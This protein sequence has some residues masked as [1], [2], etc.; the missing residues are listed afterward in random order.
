MLRTIK[1]CISLR[2]KF[3]PGIIWLIIRSVQ[4]LTDS[5]INPAESPSGS[6][7]SSESLFRCGISG[8]C[9]ITL[10]S[11]SSIS[12]NSPNMSSIWLWP[13]TLHHRQS[14][15]SLLLPFLWHFRQ[16][17]PSWNILRIIWFSPLSFLFRL[18]YVVPTACYRCIPLLSSFA[19]SGSLN[20]GW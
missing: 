10:I 20:Q 19:E 9:T 8:F 11:L 1:W 17:W 2:S 6:S 7:N 4:N 15:G 12:K 13:R 3:D 5:F 18:F 16:R 14:S